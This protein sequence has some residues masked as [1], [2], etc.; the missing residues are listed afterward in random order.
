MQI[1]PKFQEEYS[2][3][4]PAL[5]LLSNLGWTYISPQH[6]LSA[7][8][9]KV[10][11]V[12]LNQILRE[13]LAKRTFIFAGKEHAISDKA[14]DSL[15]AEVNSPALNQGLITA[16][17][18][19]YNHLLYGVFV[20][21][22]IDSKRVH[23]TISLFDWK[24][25]HNNSFVFTEEFSVIRA[26]GIE[27]CRPDIV[28]FVNGIPLVVIEAKHPDGNAKKGP[29][30]G[31]GISQS[32]RNQSYDEIPRLFAYSQILLSINGHYERYGT[33]GTPTKF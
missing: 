26:N 33:C 2:A 15:V 27:A 31:D 5:A 8:A 13:Q 11:Q 29:T 9:G 16:N 10:D 25:P 7:R 21:E 28:C 24:N 6:A 23:P 1:A 14:I 32:L 19:L 18:Y 12:V 4:L 22:F 3:K 30:I 17:E 20:T